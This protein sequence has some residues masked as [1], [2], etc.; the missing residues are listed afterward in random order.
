[1]RNKI[2]RLLEEESGL[3]PT[4]ALVVGVSG[5]PDSICLLHLLASNTNYQIV[6][7]H[8][9]HQLR[10]ESKN[11][12]AAVQAF[13]ENIGLDFVLGTEDVGKYSKE[14]GLSLEEAGRE[15]RYK[16]LFAQ[17]E[18][19][20]AK[21][22]LVGHHADDQVET[23]LMHFLR[24]S[25]LAGL[26]GMRESG[27]TQW[28][29]NIPLVR[30]LLTVRRQ[31][32]EAYCEEHAL[33]T[34][35][36]ASNQDTAFFRN[37]LRNELIPYLEGYNPRIRELVTQMADS[38]RADHAV[39]SDLA[40]KAFADC[41]IDSGPQHIALHRSIFSA[42]PLGVR[43]NLVRQA[44]NLLRPG[45]RDFGFKDTARVLEL[46]QHPPQSGQA[47]L[48]AGLRVQIDA[49]R[50]IIADWRAD[51]LDPDW[52]QWG[53]GEQRI[54]VPGR[55]LL[56]NG[57]MLISELQAPDSRV[58]EILGDNDDP[59][60]AYFAIDPQTTPLIIQNRQPGARITPFGMDAGSQKIGDLMT[61]AKLPQPARENWPLVVIEGQIVWVPGIR[62]SS[63]Y[64]L[65]EG[66]DQIVKITIERTPDHG[67]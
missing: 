55:T 52:P 2:K 42:Q 37:R 39:L 56:D 46:L 51:L 6:A 32:I 49:D 62:R 36:D 27:L 7:A 19:H 14:N 1:M 22:V 26:G 4:D 59:F 64:L 50:L 20:D 16:F 54:L 18:L 60:I 12:A 29:P 45:L 35:E 17:A 43:R 34:L 41:L 67:S 31:K 21:A 3:G 58:D 38:L 66:S 57:W 47:D 15:L 33:F 8:L 11:D 10:A 65:E 44:V 13:L 5:G 53:G 9:D 28:H 30:P 40:Q 24:G 25:G 48:T 63:Q 23:V 61:N